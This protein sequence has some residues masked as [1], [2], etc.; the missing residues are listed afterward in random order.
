MRILL[1]LR[2]TKD[3]TLFFPRRPGGGLIIEAYTDADYATCPD[4]RRSQSG[5]VIKINGSTVYAR[6]ALQ[7]IVTLSPMESE[8]VAAVECAQQVIHVRRIVEE[9]LGFT[10]SAPTRIYCD[11]DSAVLLSQRPIHHTR[12]K[13]IQVRFHWI[14]EQTDNGNPSLVPDQHQGPASGHSDQE[15]LQEDIQPNQ[16]APSWSSTLEPSLEA[17]CAVGMS[18]AP[19]NFLGSMSKLLK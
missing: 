10:Q 4:T 6:S 19:P 12:S 9:D 14:R 3:D 15:P 7:R 1:Y 18:N 2:N 8:Y 16:A 13:H 11:N 5:A 17:P